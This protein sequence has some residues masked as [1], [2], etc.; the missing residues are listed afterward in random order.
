MTDFFYKVQ[1][2]LILII[3]FFNSVAILYSLYIYHNPSNKK[4]HRFQNQNN[5]YFFIKRVVLYMLLQFILQFIIIFFKDYIIINST[6]SITSIYQSSIILLVDDIYFYFFHRLLH[7]NKFLYKH[8]HKLH[9]SAHSPYPIN[10]I[11]AHPI[12][13]F[14]GFGGSA[15]GI[16]IQG[17]I[18]SS[19]LIMYSIIKILHE[20]YIHSGVILFKFDNYYFMSFIGSVED[21][22]IH[23]YYLKG[24]YCSNFN[25]LDKL[26]GTYITPKHI[27]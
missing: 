6:I 25:Y 3:I 24:N 27:L 5:F 16:L 21:H 26:F 2:P 18:Y 7:T 9:H 20:I 12:E 15:I 22:D 19:S 14:S 17:K 23:H 10:Y 4:I 11:Y 1:V 13:I 8:I